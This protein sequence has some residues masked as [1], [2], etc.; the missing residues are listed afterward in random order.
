MGRVNVE[1]R[2]FS[3]R[4]RF[5]KYTKTAGIR[6]DAAMGR[7]L[8]LWHD[9]QAVK[10]G[11][12]NKDQI[13]MWSHVLDDSG[14]DYLKGL[15]AG[16]Y[17][18]KKG[19]DRYEIQGNKK[20]IEGHEAHL[21]GAKK[22]G[23][24][25]K[26]KWEGQ[27][28]DT[29][30]EMEG[31]VGVGKTGSDHTTQVQNNDS[32]KNN[33]NSVLAYSPEPAPMKASTLGGCVVN[34][35]QV[36]PSQVNTKQCNVNNFDSDL[37]PTAGP[38]LKKAVD[39]NLYN[40]HEGANTLLAKI[41]KDTQK[42]WIRKYGDPDWIRKEIGLVSDYLTKN[43]DKYP[44]HLGKYLSS[45]LKNSW[46][47]L[48]EPSLENPTPGPA[49]TMK[50]DLDAN[51]RCWE[52]YRE[53]YYFRWKVDPLRNAR[54]NGIIAQIVKRLNSEAT[55]VVKYFVNHNDS[56]YIKNLHDISLCL[57]NAESLR[58]QWLSGKMITHVEVKNMEARSHTVSQLQR[59]ESGEL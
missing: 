25:T 17:V 8:F 19:K 9:S 54:T 50:V 43:P 2:A 33:E 22:G 59:I 13:L 38:D 45:S 3:E 58:T 12:G 35:N 16:G 6:E 14:E 26:K 47:Q 21:Q 18:I 7:L 52:S 28:Q 48:T 41:P 32:N 4:G 5:E 27:T 39:P 10:K 42:S 20:Q 56:F 40:C 55:E 15:L 36:N 49:P 57:K 44:A 23:L 30:I 31:S 51:K 11:F 34:S 24:A 29:K 46:K 37:G 53:A 1:E